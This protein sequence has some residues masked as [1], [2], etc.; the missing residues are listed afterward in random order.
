VKNNALLKKRGHYLKEND[1]MPY[2]SP[3][4]EKDPGPQNRACLNCVVNDG[5]CA[6][7]GHEHE[8]G[9]A[10]SCPND[11]DD[12]DSDD[13]GI[14]GGMFF[15]PNDFTRVNNELHIFPLDVTGIIFGK[16]L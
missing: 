15:D 13:E 1:E 11:L 14:F 10:E 9:H 12:D 3:M 2:Y 7:C 4:D 5:A 6:I 16:L 8:Y